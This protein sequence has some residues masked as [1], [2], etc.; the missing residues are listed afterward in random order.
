MFLKLYN[1]FVPMFLILFKSDSQTVTRISFP[2]FSNMK[3][4]TLSKL[5]S[6]CK[7]VKI[8]VKKYGFFYSS[9]QVGNG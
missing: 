9:V 6:I 8:C 3:L 7:Y 4:H 1:I 2:E 5:G